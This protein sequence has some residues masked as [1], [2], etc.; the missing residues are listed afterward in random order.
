MTLYTSVQQHGDMGKLRGEIAA[1]VPG[2]PSEG[3]DNLLKEYEQKTAF[4][5]NACYLV[6]AYGIGIKHQSLNVVVHAFP[7]H[8]KL[9]EASAPGQYL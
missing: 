2:F 5:S 1:A 9:V 8:E 3:I 6:M 7:E 4:I